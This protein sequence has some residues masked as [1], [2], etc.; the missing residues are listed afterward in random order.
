MNNLDSQYKP[1][2]IVLG[3]F[4]LSPFIPI[5]IHCTPRLVGVD[6]FGQLQRGQCDDV[7]VLREAPAV[8]RD[9]LA[10]EWAGRGPH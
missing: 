3:D 10:G 7:A 5:S 2:T 6:G 9:L 1:P 8:L 4:V